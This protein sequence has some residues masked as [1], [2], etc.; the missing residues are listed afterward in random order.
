MLAAAWL[1]SP[2]RSPTPCCLPATRVLRTGP[3]SSAGNACVPLH[4]VTGQQLTRGPSLHHLLEGQEKG[5]E[6][7]RPSAARQARWGLRTH[8]GPSSREHQP[9]ADSPVVLGR[10]D[11]SGREDAERQDIRVDQGLVRFRGVS[12]ATY[13][14]RGRLHVTSQEGRRAPGPHSPPL[15]GR[16][17]PATRLCHRAPHTA[18]GAPG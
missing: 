11:V 16:E 7:S 10:A 5:L 4:Q 15:P 12:D 3:S 1:G 2:A 14:K 18:T 8:P 6:S 9:R 13:G 17:L